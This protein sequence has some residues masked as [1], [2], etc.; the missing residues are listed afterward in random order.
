MVLKTVQVIKDTCDYIGIPYPK[1]HEVNWN[2]Q[3]VW[4]DMLSSP[5][6]IFQFEGAFA[7]ECLRKF[8]PHSI[9]DMSIVTACIRPSG[10]SYRNDLL[11]RKIHKNPSEIIDNLLEENLG[12]LIYQEDTIRFLQEI[13]GLSGSEADNIRRAIGRKQK[14][15]LDK[16]MPS[17]LDGYCSKSPK[18]RADAEEEAKE[19]L[20]IIEDSA[21]YQ[22]GKNHSIAYCLLGYLCAYYR[23]YY[24]IE[25]ITSF[26]NNAANEDDI[27][28][29]TAYANRVGIKIT[30]PK[31]G[32]SKSHYF[33][34][35]DKNVIA[36]G[37]TSIKYMGDGL[38]EELYDM[39]KERTYDRFIDLL[40]HMDA[41]SSIDSRQVGI[42]IKIDFFSEFGNQRELLRIYDFFYSN[43]MKK[44]AVKKIKIDAV[45]GLIIEGIIRKYS[46]NRTKN[47][48]MAKSYTVLDPM[49]ILR[50]YEDVVKSVG[51]DDLDVKIKIQN[52]YELM[53]YYGYS[54]G[55]DEDRQKLFVLDLYPLYRKRDGKQFG[56][57]VITKS[58]GSGK[59]SRFT[60]FNRVFDKEPIKKGDIIFCKSF[61]RDGIYFTLNS[62]YKDF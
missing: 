33:F 45:D 32:L 6:G 41:G 57:S 54:T 15:R 12:Y 29:G 10:T 34:D 17:I 25:F 36:K 2:D 46:T 39:S 27:K 60:V 20:Q 1:S 38:A 14:D 58:I 49:G 28:N 24:P 40:A 4:S 11:A 56:Y 26:L 5:V 59:E 23:H 37:I 19:F 62:Y 51:M 53:G 9:S 18:D 16:A 52:F 43:L 44:G 47:G 8:E 7:M 31:W 35:K 21:S 48:D 55:K 3:E 50:E 22:F 13:C 30:M 61:T 42:L